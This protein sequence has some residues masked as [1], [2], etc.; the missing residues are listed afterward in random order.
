MRR[1]VSLLLIMSTSAAA[2]TRDAGVEAVQQCLAVIQ[3][4]NQC[5][6]FITVQSVK[7]VDRQIN[8]TAATVIAEIN[9][10]VTQSFGGQGPLARACTGTEWNMN[11]S[12]VRASTPDPRF[13]YF[14]VGQVLQVHPSFGFQKFESGWRCSTTNLNSPGATAYY[15]NNRP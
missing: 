15:M 14:L 6:P 12:Q 11:P 9:L 1:W 10:T 8:G 3:Q 4:Q 2:Q 13:A 7:Q 5:S